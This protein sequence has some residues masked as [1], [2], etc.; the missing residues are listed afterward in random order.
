[1]S[2]GFVLNVIEDRHERAETL[3]APWS[4][5]RRVLSVAVMTA[6]KVSFAGLRPH[7]DGHVTS[8][9]TFQKYYGQQELR[10]FLLEVLGEPPVALA[11]GIFAV[12]R[13]KDLEQEVLLRR[14]SRGIMRPAGMR[15]PVRERA[16]A[17]K[18]RPGLAERV[19]AELETLWGAMLERGRSYRMMP[20]SVMISWHLMSS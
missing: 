16:A 13:D 15:P 19:R 2:L 18:Q 10:D 17:S 1:V 3:R 11:P 8:R 7:R 5:A 12:F 4:F 14:R 20:R 9:G 6:G